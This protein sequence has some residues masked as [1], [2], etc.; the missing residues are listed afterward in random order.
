MDVWDLSGGQLWRAVARCGQCVFV[1][2]NCCKIHHV[3]G[4]NCRTVWVY[5]FLDPKSDE[6]RVL[7]KMQHPP[8]RVCTQTSFI[9]ID[10]GCRIPYSV[11]WWFLF[12]FPG[13]GFHGAPYQDWTKIYQTPPNSLVFLVKALPEGDFALRY[14]GEAQGFDGGMASVTILWL[15]RVL[16]GTPIFNI[17][18]T[19]DTLK[20]SV[21]H[22]SK[23]GSSCVEKIHQ[24]K[25][26][27]EQFLQ[28]L[29]ANTPFR[30]HPFYCWVSFRV[31]LGFL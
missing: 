26:K 1:S 18:Y 30:P 16:K 23:G 6:L 10:T 28:K 13:T 21:H 19:L 25:T 4:L 12:I 8:S 5:P 2:W 27:I 22:Y 3:G 9:S 31:S 11:D 24:T 7:G 29:R 17:R 14:D 15:N 20:I